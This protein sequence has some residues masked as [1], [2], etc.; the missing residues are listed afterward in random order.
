MRR[1]IQRL[2]EGPIARLVLAGEVAR[3]GTVALAVADGAL[4]VEPA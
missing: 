2:V 4:V 3:G 1:T